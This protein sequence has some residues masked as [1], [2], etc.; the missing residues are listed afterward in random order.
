[1]GTCSECIERHIRSARERTSTARKV[2]Q[3]DSKDVTLWRAQSDERDAARGGARERR[4]TEGAEERLERRRARRKRHV[5][6]DRDAASAVR[7]AL[8]ER[9]PFR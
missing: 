9:W 2:W 5:C 7:M 8:G 1:M 3:R 4:E 6:A